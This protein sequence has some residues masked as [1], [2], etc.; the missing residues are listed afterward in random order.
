MDDTILITFANQKGGVGKTTLCA[1]FANYLVKK[2]CPVMVVDCDAQQSIK[3]RRKNDLLVYG[4]EDMKLPYEVISFDITK[5]EQLLVFI[6]NLRQ[7][8]GIVLIDSPG[9]LDLQGLVI[10]LASSDFIVCPFHYD[11]TTI[12]STVSFIALVE[13]IRNEMG[14]HMSAQLILIPN[15]QDPRVGKRD[16]LVLWEETREAFSN[17]GKVTPKITVRADMERFST[18][19]DLDN[20]LEI[21]SPAFDVIFKEIF[22]TTESLIKQ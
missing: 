17:Y 15:K 13:R 5:T 12:P 8:R 2:G 22:G 7:S 20:Q 18:I 3:E 16:E 1:I 21:V 9:T 14:K 19:S 11:K 6:E 10:L 4:S